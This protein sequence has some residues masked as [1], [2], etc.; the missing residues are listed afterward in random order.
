MLLWWIWVLKRLQL[1]KTDVNRQ[2]TSKLGK[3]LHRFDST[4]TAFRKHTT[5]TEN[6]IKCTNMMQ[7]A[8]MKQKLFPKDTK[9]DEHGLDK[10]VVAMVCH[11]SYWVRFAYHWFMFI[12]DYMLWISEFSSPCTYTW[13][14]CT[15]LQGLAEQSKCNSMSHFNYVRGNLVFMTWYWSF[16][17]VSPC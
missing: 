3:H 8:Q 16:L 12:I 5:N 15:H 7:G 11:S 1:K 9:S 6:T 10:H 14:G 4:C 17:S 2:N 13:G